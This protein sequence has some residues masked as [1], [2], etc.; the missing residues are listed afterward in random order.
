MVWLQ[1]LLPDLGLSLV[2]HLHSHLPRTQSL[3]NTFLVPGK[4]QGISSIQKSFHS[5]LS[6][7]FKKKNVVSFLNFIPS[8]EHTGCCI[9]YTVQKSQYIYLHLNFH[10]M[11]APYENNLLYSSR[12]VT[13]TCVK[14]NI[15]NRKCPNY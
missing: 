10:E 4:V 14:K 7:I 3:G 1:P 6:V 9:Q 13:L 11:L 15:E 8:Y 12:L 5:I 2:L